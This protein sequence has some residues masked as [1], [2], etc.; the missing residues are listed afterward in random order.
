MNYSLLEVIENHKR[1]NN[2]PTN[3]VF[4]FLEEAAEHSSERFRAYMT[5]LQ[6]HH[7]GLFHGIIFASS[8]ILPLNTIFGKHNWGEVKYKHGSSS[9]VAAMKTIEQ[10]FKIDLNKISEFAEWAEASFRNSLS[11][12]DYLFIRK[13]C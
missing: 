9:I 1:L 5:M 13:V 6:T 7:H 2:F 3:Q 4:D 10:L 11:Q 12:G 8:D